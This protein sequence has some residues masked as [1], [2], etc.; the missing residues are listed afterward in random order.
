MLEEILETTKDYPRFDDGRIDYTTA[1][2]CPVL[3]CVVV[4]GDE[5]LLTL[6]SKEV[7]A[8]PE[9]WNGISGFIDVI[10]PLE[11]IARQELEEELGVRAQDIKCV[12]IKEKLVQTDESINREWHV[13]PIL[14]ELNAKPKI[15]VNWENKEARWMLRQE[16]LKLNLVPGFSKVFRIATQEIK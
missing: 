4:F 9:M 14:V 7:I 16:V 12:V 2:V 3:N 1:R 6:R 8:Y 11:E 10:K 5:V 13:F 15:A